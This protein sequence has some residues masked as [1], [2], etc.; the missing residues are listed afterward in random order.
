MSQIIAPGN[1]TLIPVFSPERL[2]LTPGGE[3]RFRGALERIAADGELKA[4]L[5]LVA[6]DHFAARGF[7]GVQVKEVAEEAGVSKPTL[8]YH[9][10]TKE[11]PLRQPC[12][13]ALAV[14]EQRLR[15]MV[16]PHLV[17]KPADAAA[18]RASALGLSASYVDL[19]MEL[20]QFTGFILRAIAVPG[21][22]ST[23]RDLMPLVERALSPLG[24]YVHHAFS[25]DFEQARKEVMVYTA[26]FGPLLEEHLLRPDSAIAA[27]EISRAVD[28][29][30]RGIQGT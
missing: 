18:V 4:K 13:V 23:F 8:T 25:L 17:A 21:P 14:T 24:L 27:R 6:L 16:A 30:L 7:D 12:L 20:P 28:R 3:A 15:D 2:G 11:G 10:G 22:D 29:W 9:F 19:L 1:D 5:L 26:I